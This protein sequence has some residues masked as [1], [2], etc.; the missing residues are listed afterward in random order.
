MKN[1]IGLGR[2]RSLVLTDADKQAAKN[3]P[4][5]LQAVIDGI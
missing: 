3:A 2:N 1:E 5:G 4:L